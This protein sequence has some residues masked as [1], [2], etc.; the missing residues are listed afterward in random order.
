MEPDDRSVLRPSGHL[1][2]AWGRGPVCCPAAAGSR[3]EEHLSLWSVVSG[4]EPLKP[5]CR[6][7]SSA[8]LGNFSDLSLTFCGATK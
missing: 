7:L 4:L 2:P 1:A 5:R 3:V 8:L 6:D